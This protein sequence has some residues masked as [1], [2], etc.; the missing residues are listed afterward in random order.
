VTGTEV[1][2]DGNTAS[3]DG[4]DSNCTPTACG[5][6]TMSPGETC[7]D[8]NVTDGDG[9]DSNCTP[10]A[11]G[12]G[13]IVGSEVCDTGRARIEILSLGATGCQ[14][15]E[16][17]V[18]TGDDK[19][20][21][22]IGTTQLFYTGDYTTGRFALNDLANHG[23]VAYRDAL[24]SDLNSGKI[25][26]L[27]NGGTP[28][29]YGG[30]AVTSLLTLNE[31]TGAVTGQLNL[32][33][34]I[35][36]GDGAGLFSGSGEIAIYVESSPR[37]VYQINTQTGAV[38]EHVV[39]YT[40]NRKLCESWATWGVAERIGGA[41]H[42]S[43]VNASTILRTRV[44][45]GTTTTLASFGNLGDMCS[46]TV[47]PSQQRWYFHYEGGAQ[48]GGFDESV[49][50]CPASILREAETG[51]GCN[52]SCQVEIG[53]SC[54]G[55][56]S[57]C[58]A[59]CGDGV[60]A[61][62]AEQC[63]DGDVES[64]DG[65]DAN[66]RPTGCGSGIVTAGE[67]CDDGNLFSGDGCDANCTPTACGN[68]VTTGPEQCDDGDAESGDG[69]DANCRPT[70]CGS[71]IV[72][73]GETCDDG[74]PVNGDG[75][76]SNCTPTAC[77]NGVTSPGEACDDGDL[78]DGDGCDS[79]CTPTACGNM[80]VTAGEQCDTGQTAMAIASLDATGCQVIDHPSVTGDDRGGIAVG[81]NQLFYTGDSATG[82]FALNDLNDYASLVVRDALVSDLDSGQILSLGN[83]GT[84]HG[85]GAGTVTSL[86]TLDEMTGAVID[87]L[88]L[89]Q[90]VVLAS[91]AGLFAGYGEVAIYNDSSP[92]RV[93]RIDTETGSVTDIPVAFFLN[94]S[95]CENW[96]F[97]GVADR[98]DGELHLNYVYGSDVLRTRVSDG[99]T[100]AV[101]S[102]NDLSDMCS[103]TV[104]PSEQRWYF[105]HEYTSQ[106]GGSGNEA[107]GFCDASI[108]LQS[109]GGGGCDEF[110]QVEPGYSCTGAP[111]VCTAIC[112]DGFVTSAEDCDDTNSVNGDGCD[113]NCTATGC[114]N[115]IATS[116][117][118][119]DDGNGVGNDGCE[120]DCT[121]SC[122]NGLLGA[123]EECDDGN[124]FDGDGCD[125]TCAFEYC[126]DGLVN[127]D[128]G[129]V[130]VRF[131]WLHTCQN[132]GPSRFFVNG[133]QAASVIVPYTCSCLP[134]IQSVRI[135]DPAILSAVIAGSNVFAVD[136]R[137][138]VAWAV[139]VVET[140]R[141][142][143]QQTVVFDHE[144]GGHA[145]A[146]QPDLCV[147]YYTS[148]DVNT[149]APGT[150][151]LAPDEAC[152]DGDTD[153]GDGCSSVCL[154]EN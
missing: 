22:A 76:D 60:I 129:V 110:C 150:V 88:D 11:C 72:T 149:S 53:Y 111:S 97:W 4:C 65:C 58:T 95:G 8:G 135:T 36:V 107:I 78:S 34:A 84:P 42:L 113:N 61:A 80:I 16:H 103:F 83:G 27:G 137:G 77:G 52:A 138:Y 66:C 67:T 151:T 122:G 40:L 3:G 54:S 50:F 117:E 89:S 30:G 45:D 79:N 98:H 94:R 143:N 147:S 19:G 128:D 96:A 108:D 2:D 139:A 154:L 102:F 123:G 14:I 136:I 57:L 43:Y 106:F 148:G 91:S 71:G 33:Q 6:N 70:G 133:T 101:A 62:G 141:G 25:L 152:D 153:N 115:G 74:N 121:L 56:P 39:G 5:N 37:R 104:S 46:F 100:T 144:G 18:L 86:L 105:H 32:S 82:R 93:Y 142:D 31:N 17:S 35:L 145:L 140:N 124:D 51:R 114:G 24:V 20:A 134:G 64:G 116:G 87:Q 63:D 132:A 12:N 126:G 90:P 69:C 131:E 1:C 99:F 81:A 10:T 85:Y 7:D 21:I 15:I 9:C 125:S 47:S 13:A 26:S 127:D 49:G 38:V 75:C 73:A 120:N 146:R 29:G 112:G 41:L 109:S 92:R 28:I 119:C 48:F 59:T 44:S 68:N 130:A 23:P 118:A 55:E